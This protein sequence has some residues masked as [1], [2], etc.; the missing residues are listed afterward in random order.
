MPLYITEYAYLAKDVNGVAS[1]TPAAA[2]RHTSY[3]IATAA[4]NSLTFH[5]STRFI[6]MVA[7][8]A[9]VISIGVSPN[10]SVSGYLLPA[11]LPE[12][13]GVAGTDAETALV[14]FKMFV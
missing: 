3:T 9:S 11:N 13:F 14:S 2:L 10:A 12:I 5:P 6:R 4:A 8:T 7:H 1:G